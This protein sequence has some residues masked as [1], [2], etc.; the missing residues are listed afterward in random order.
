MIRAIGFDGFVR[1]TR[2]IVARVDSRPSL[3][4]ISV[5]TLALVGDSDPLTPLECSE[6]IA[7][8]IPNARLAVATQ[9][10]HAST[11]EQPEFVNCA[12]LEWIAG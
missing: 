11:L 1:Q 8:A 10:G 2:A 9:C 4:A 12:L 7:A 3:V 6:E 5:P